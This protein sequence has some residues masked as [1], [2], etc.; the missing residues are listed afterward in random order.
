MGSSG[1]CFDHVLPASNQEASNVTHRNALYQNVLE[2]LESAPGVKS[3]A[4]SNSWPP[5]T[6]CTELCQL[7]GRDRESVK[8]RSHCL[9]CCH[10]VA[11]T[12]GSSL[13]ISLRRRGR[14]RS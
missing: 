3:A 13:R 12:G 2:Q 8:R 4:F 11:G 6:S 14:Y 5:T 9:H 7:G 10:S 1:P